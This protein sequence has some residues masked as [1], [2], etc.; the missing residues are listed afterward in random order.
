MPTRAVPHKLGRGVYVFYKIYNSS[1]F[2]ILLFFRLLDREQVRDEDAA[3]ND[4]EEDS[5][6]KA[7]KV[8]I[9]S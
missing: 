4:E 2:F 5:F 6:L 9:Y 3:V 7:F 1:N 8:F